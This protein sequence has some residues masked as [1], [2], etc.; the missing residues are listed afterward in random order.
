MKL[1]KLACILIATALGA[2]SQPTSGP[3]KDAASGVSELER[4]QI[5]EAAR[6]PV[7]GR[8]AYACGIEFPVQ[9]SFATLDVGGD[10][11]VARV[12][13][14]SSA[15]CYGSAGARTI[16]LTRRQ[17]RFVVILS[18]LGTSVE[19]LSTR[20]QGVSDLR[21]SAPRENQRSYRWNG[22]HYERSPNAVANGASAERRCGWL[23]NPTPGNLLLIDKDASWWIA[24]Q[25]EAMGPNAEGEV[26][27]FDRR[28]FVTTQ[29]GYGYGCA[30]LNVA[31]DAPR[32]RITR[33][34]SAENLPLARSR[35][36]RSLPAPPR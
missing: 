31:T 25:G 13:T 9:A 5:L 19:M 21:I 23:A 34:I 2:C 11:G 33:V 29:S 7:H 3:E 14:L 20:T 10:I 1:R 17:G 28:E 8:R 35:N 15:A 32:Q 26:P 27:D 12:L 22:A 4:K 30:C 24:S 6:V 36:D 18:E 16:L